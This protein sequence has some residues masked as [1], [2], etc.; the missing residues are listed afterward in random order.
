MQLKKHLICALVL[1]A[2]FLCSTTFAQQ[3]ERV[4][5]KE[6]LQAHTE[7]FQPLS[8]ERDDLYKRF[9]NR[10]LSVR[11]ILRWLK[12]DPKTAEAKRVQE[13][14]ELEARLESLKE[15]AKFTTPEAI[16]DAAATIELANV[17]IEDIDD[18]RTTAIKPLS[19]KQSALQRKYQDQ[20][21]KLKPAVLSVFREAGDSEATSGL[22]RSYASFSY[23]SGSASGTY[24]REDG[25]KAAC[26]CYVYLAND[27]VAK[28]KYGKF[29]EK[30]PIIYCSKNQLEVLVGPCRVTV[31][32]R[33][34]EFSDK[35]L[36]A[37]MSALVD[38]EKI[39]ALLA[40]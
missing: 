2:S 22:T 17:A 18:E 19:R 5:M 37:T 3:D 25:T 12:E 15:F 13:I 7:E 6:C 30:Y 27:K 34:K 21:G 28:D 9:S 20:E 1:T 32:S 31:Y 24:K 8:N 33:D 26:T 36:D 11:N 40:P 16:E 4:L 38:F 14:S 23:S 39:E 35:S 29:E 10:S